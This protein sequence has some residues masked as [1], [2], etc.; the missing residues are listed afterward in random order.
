M[1][2]SSAMEFE[3]HQRAFQFLLG[4][5][6]VITAFISDRHSQIARWMRVEC[7]QRCK[8]LGKPVITHFFDLWHIAKSK[9]LKKYRPVLLLL[10]LQ[11]E[12]WMRVRCGDWWGVGC[13][14]QW[15][16]ESHNLST[17]SRTPKVA[18]Q[19]KQG[20]RNGGSWTMEESMCPP[21]VLGSYF[22][23]SKAWGCY[24]G[25]VQG[26]SVPYTEPTHQHTWE[27]VQQVCSWSAYHSTFVANKR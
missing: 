3:G 19:V 9:L 7:P 25:K 6:M 27:V 12:E 18:D 23:N 10:M 22:H 8:A 1:G 24:P 11:K 16:F 15:I 4:T 21:P 17:P 2:S 13:I 26:I 20:E 5:A 14:L